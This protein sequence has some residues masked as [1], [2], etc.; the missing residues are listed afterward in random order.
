[1][2]AWWCR[3]RGKDVN[4]MAEQSSGLATMQ[5]S[6]TSVALKETGTSSP[7]ASEEERVTSHEENMT[8]YS[9]GAADVQTYSGAGGDY[10]GSGGGADRGGC[11]NMA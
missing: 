1:M 5:A 10:G 3:L 8:Y 9:A 11:G 7:F 4:V 6:Q 2:K